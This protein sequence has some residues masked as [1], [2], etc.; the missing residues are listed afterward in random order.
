MNRLALTV[1]SWVI[2]HSM[3]Y[4]SLTP[5]KNSTV[6][7]SPPAQQTSAETLTGALANTAGKR[8]NS[9]FVLTRDTVVLLD[10]KPCKYEEVPGHAKIERMELAVDKKTVITIHFATKK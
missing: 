6:F 8:T 9:E 7:G 1:T 4:A 2:L 5:P 10:G 3:A